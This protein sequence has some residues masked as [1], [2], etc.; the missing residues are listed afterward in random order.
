MVRNP[1]NKDLR[2]YLCVFVRGFSPLQFPRRAVVP[3]KFN[4]TGEG[5]KGPD[6][7][8]ERE[9]LLVYSDLSF[10]RGH[11]TCAY[12]CLTSIYSNG[13]SETRFNGRMF[14]NRQPTVV[15]D[16]NDVCVCVCA[17]VSKGDVPVGC[18]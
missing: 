8:R 16:K 3:P 11:E 9:R 1:F 2:V 12:V 14:V 7:V 13:Y 17:C 4:H 15:V 6:T 18:T 5:E 10:Q